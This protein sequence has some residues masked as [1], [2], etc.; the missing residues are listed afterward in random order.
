MIGSGLVLN[1]PV[2]MNLRALLR[3]HGRI[4]GF[5]FVL[6]LLSSFGQT[7]F[8]SLSVPDVRASFRLSHGEFG[9]IYSTATLASGLL[10]IWVGG[11][12]D[13]VSVRLYAAVALS[14]LCLA[15]LGLSLSPN[16]ALLG[17]SLFA[18]RLCGQGMLSHAA[19]TSTARL[20]DGIRG[21]AVGIATLGFPAGEA[22]LPGIGIALIATLGW[23]PT[24]QAVA[25]LLAGCLILGILATPR[26]RVLDQ[27]P[28]DR[29]SA[30]AALDSPR[31]RDLL[32]NPR[33]LL[34]IPSIVAPSAILTAVIF[35]Q[36]YIAEVKGWP[37]ELLAGSIT[38]YAL[39][40]LTLTFTTGAVI[41]RF[42]AVLLSRFYLLG[43]AAGGV[44]LAVLEAPSAALVVF[45]LLGVTAGA[46]NTVMPAV[47]AELF[48]TLHLGRVRALAGSMTV[49]ASATTP[50]TVGFLF[51][52]GISPGALGLGFAAY[53][54]A[55]S[56]M[57]AILLRR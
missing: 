3:T 36:R 40:S 12:L 22:F 13:Q 37:L 43:I 28:I 34:F 50:G 35:H 53:A 11:L 46:N 16:I 19:V 41:D 39:A 29:T 6:A 18:L 14:G 4:V 57:N 38:S 7:S 44:A 52:L 48:G 47:L 56:T 31:R 24:W 55:V 32:K 10:M 45:A 49:V 8:I 54:V 23:T 33:F 9:A 26:A 30:R 17:V 1:P 5:G 25:G 20:P 27:A 51:D 2:R 15:A 42:G 21:R